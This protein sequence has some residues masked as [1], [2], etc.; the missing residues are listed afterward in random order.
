MIDD[1][2]AYI[3]IIVVV[4]IVI[5]VI[6]IMGISIIVRSPVNQAVIQHHLASGLLPLEPSILP[7]RWP[8]PARS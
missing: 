3:I 5:V 6:V 4:I 1:Y 2:D 7:P 8:T